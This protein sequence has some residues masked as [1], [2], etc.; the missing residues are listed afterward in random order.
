MKYIHEIKALVVVNQGCES[1]RVKWKNFA[2]IADHDLVREAI[3]MIEI[4]D[5]R[6][7]E[8]QKKR[9]AGILLLQNPVE[10]K[11]RN[12]RRE[13]LESARIIRSI[14]RSI[15]REKAEQERQNIN[16]IGR[17]S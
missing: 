17:A 8:I 2:E 13:V 14:Y 15:A 10:S 4:F 16:R 9:F 6:K 5:Y 3:S 12:G 7:R 1:G 11:E